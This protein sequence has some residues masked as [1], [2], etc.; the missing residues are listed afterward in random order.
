MKWTNR[1]RKGHGT[2]RRWQAHEGKALQKTNKLPFL[3]LPTATRHLYQN[4][5]SASRHSFGSHSGGRSG[6]DGMNI[7]T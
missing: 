3:A 5:Y 2:R 4:M 6:I 7:N 1:V